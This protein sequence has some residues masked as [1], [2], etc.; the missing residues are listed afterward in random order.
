MALE[1]VYRIIHKA[2]R[3]PLKDRLRYLQAAYAAEKG[4]HRRKM[5]HQAMVP[6]CVRVL[7]QEDR[8]QS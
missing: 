1:P 6:L 7:K 5:I 2:D 3:W 4:R 8:G